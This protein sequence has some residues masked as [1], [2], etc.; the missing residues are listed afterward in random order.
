MLL[1]E[2]DKGFS[3]QAAE[4]KP[5]S[6]FS[7]P[8]EVQSQHTTQVTGEVRAERH[9]PVSIPSDGHSTDPATIAGGSNSPRA[10]QRPRCK[11]EAL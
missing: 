4:R 2:T 8:A 7:L 5:H 10:T 6:S 3:R 1:I 11:F 9:R